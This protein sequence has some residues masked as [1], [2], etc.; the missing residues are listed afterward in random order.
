[1]RDEEKVIMG[2]SEK[3]ILERDFA[4]DDARLSDKAKDDHTLAIESAIES[5]EVPVDETALEDGISEEGTLGTPDTDIAL[6]KPQLDDSLMDATLL[7][8]ALEADEAWDA[9][10]PTQSVKDLKRKKRKKIAVI[11]GAIIFV[12]LIL[13]A[14]VIYDRFF[15]SANTEAEP[16]I[17]EV[18]LSD[19]SKTI[20]ETGALRPISSTLVAAPL[21]GTIEELYIAE[22]DEVKKGDKLFLIKNPE[23]DEAIHMAQD[24]RNLAA[25]GVTQAQN[26]VNSLAAQINTAQTQIAGLR[27]QFDAATDL[28]QKKALGEQIV[29]LNAA[30]LDLESTLSQS[31][32]ALTE[33]NGALNT[34]DRAL[35]K[36]T[37]ERDNRLVIAP[38]DG[39]IVGLNVNRGSVVAAGVTTPVGEG[40][41]DS[42]EM[43]LGAAQSAVLEIADLS[44][45]MVRAAISEN[46]IASVEEGQKVRITIEALPDLELSGKVTRIAPQSTPSNPMDMYDSSASVTYNVDVRIDK[47][48]PRLRIGMTGEIVIEVIALTDVIVIPIDALIYEGADTFV[49]LQQ[50]DGSSV[51]RKVKTGDSNDTEVVII[52]G[53]KAGDRIELPFSGGGPFEADAVLVGG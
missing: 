20:S 1:L 45:M 11:L 44:A 23:L 18:S 35:N 32:G 36:A 39:V 53:L 8:P 21:S 22:G 28:E 38:S 12:A 41:V 34:A 43:G 25:S 16:T 31:R 30:V 51:Q 48:D 42:G 9:Q 47:L 14:W 40:A 26:V 17:L 33:A 5:I 46:D 24:S 19:F 10:L 2:T 7:M 27:Q 3:S 13:G 37:A 50:R 4:A 15:N 29:T 6:E 52:D 49:K